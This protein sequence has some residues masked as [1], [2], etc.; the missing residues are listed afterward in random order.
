[1]LFNQRY[2]SMYKKVQSIDKNN[3]NDFTEGVDQRWS[4]NGGDTKKEPKILFFFFSA[5]GE[6]HV[7][8]HAGQVLYHWAI[9]PASDKWFLTVN[10]GYRD[11]S[12]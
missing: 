1:M 11:T 5:E 7:F 12:K 6:T 3:T 2:S 9:I 10:E 8:A 4:E